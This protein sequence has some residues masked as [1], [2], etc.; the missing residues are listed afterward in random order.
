MKKEYRYFISY[1]SNKRI[2]HAAVTRDAPLSLDN[3]EDSINNI[4]DSVGIDRNNLIVTFIF[5]YCIEY[6]F[7][8]FGKEF[9]IRRTHKP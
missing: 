8:L 6:T 1:Q 4:A 9:Y 2:G 7:K 3:F 5:L